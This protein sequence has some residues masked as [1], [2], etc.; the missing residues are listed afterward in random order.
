MTAIGL[1]PEA[2]VVGIRRINNDVLL[3]AKVRGR[4]QRYIACY[5]TSHRFQ[6]Y[7]EITS[8][9]RKRVITNSLDKHPISTLDWSLIKGKWFCYLDDKSLVPVTPS[10]LKAPTDYS[11]YLWGDQLISNKTL[12]Q[13]IIN[14]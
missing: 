1:D 13:E 14:R 2:V 11:V 8:S 3:R 9:E 5:D 7:R 10:K 12:K 4:T 6:Y